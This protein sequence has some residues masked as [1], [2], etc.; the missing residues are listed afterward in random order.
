VRNCFNL[1]NHFPW[2][3]ANIL[4]LSKTA[5]G[6]AAQTSARLVSM[7]CLDTIGLIVRDMGKS[8][9]FYRLLGLPIPDGHDD[10]DHVELPTP[11]G[12][13]LGFDTEEMVRR[14]YPGWQEPSGQRI[15]LQFACESPAEVDAV[16]V[17]LVAAGYASYKEPWDAFWGQRFAR[18]ADPDGNVVNLFAPLPK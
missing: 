16:H 14:L 2:P 13:T 3:D 7:V 5:V 9:A 1:T 6:A 11:G 15:N 8:L 4:P 12:P 18:V 10:A 17:R